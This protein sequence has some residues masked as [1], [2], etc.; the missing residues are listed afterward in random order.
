MMCRV[1]THPPQHTNDVK[2]RWLQAG[3]ARVNDRLGE[4]GTPVVVAVGT[5][6]SEGF[7]VVGWMDG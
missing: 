7:V 4:I 2:N 6:V 1:L 5:E 3:T